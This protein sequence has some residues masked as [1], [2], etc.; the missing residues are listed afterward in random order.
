MHLHRRWRWCLVALR[1]PPSFHMVTGLGFG[2]RKLNA[3]DLVYTISRI[4]VEMGNPTTKFGACNSGRSAAREG[5]SLPS[6]RKVELGFACVCV[7][8]ACV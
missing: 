3:A 7:K 1:G 8:H 5:V 2:T 4:R 6:C